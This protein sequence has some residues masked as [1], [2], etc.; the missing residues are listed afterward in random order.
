MLHAA[1]GLVWWDGKCRSGLSNV[2]SV[3]MFVDRFLVLSL[4][5]GPQTDR[6]QLIETLCWHCVTALR[7]LEYVV[8]CMIVSWKKAHLDFGISYSIFICIIWWF[9][10]LKLVLLASMTFQ[11]W[12]PGNRDLN[13]F[14]VSFKQ[15][16]RP[17]T[18]WPWKQTIA[19]QFFIKAWI[20]WVW[21]K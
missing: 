8:K 19:N 13:E 2:K 10:F 1:F 11:H 9:G 3:H 14:N 4:T 5:H 16:P 17:R 6:S 7:S 15:V 18:P 12:W 21:K 20:S